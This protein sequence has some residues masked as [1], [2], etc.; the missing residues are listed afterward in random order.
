MVSLPQHPLNRTRIRM[1]VQQCWRSYGFNVHL[2]CFNH[3]I[4]DLLWY[5]YRNWGSHWKAHRRRFLPHFD[6]RAIRLQSWR[7]GSWGKSWKKEVSNHFF[8]RFVGFLFLT[9]FPSVYCLPPSVTHQDLN[10]TYPA[11]QSSNTWCQKED[12]GLWNT[13]KVGSLLWC[14]SD[15]QMSFLPPWISQRSVWLVGSPLEKWERISSRVSWLWARKTSKKD[16]LLMIPTTSLFPPNLFLLW[17]VNSERITNL[18][19]LKSWIEK[20]GLPIP[21]S[22]FLSSTILSFLLI[23]FCSSIYH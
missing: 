12:V 4:F 18:I 1:D 13:L 23:I 7:I 20:L 16:C 19:S 15:S 2:T 3:W 17:Q 9:L 22:C 11:E 6:W 8:S 5:S 10:I 14:L 21:T